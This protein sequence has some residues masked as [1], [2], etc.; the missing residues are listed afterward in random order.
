MQY[1]AILGSDSSLSPEPGTPEFEARSQGYMRFGEQSGLVHQ[2]VARPSRTPRR[3]PPSALVTAARWS[4]T[5][6]YA[7]T[8]EAI[9]GFYSWRRTRSTTPSSWRA[10]IPAASA[11]WVTLRPLAG[12]WPYD[13]EQTGAFAGQGAYGKKTP[14]DQ[15]GT[16]EWE[17][18]G[19]AHMAFVAGAGPAVLAGNRPPT[20]APWRPRSRS[21]TET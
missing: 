9:A 15:P 4:P 11:G 1:L 6:P 8:T 12:W 16:P 18:A 2:G 7:E 14:T 17:K 13:H 21:G 3:R 20:P 10:R 19:E 5:G